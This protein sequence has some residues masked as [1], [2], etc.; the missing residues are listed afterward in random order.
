MMLTTESRVALRELA[1]HLLSNL[2]SS[3]QRIIGTIN[4]FNVW[5]HMI[6]QYHVQKF[7]IKGWIIQFISRFLF[8]A[9]KND[10]LSLIR[11][12][13]HE[14]NLEHVK[15]VCSLFTQLD[16]GYLHPGITRLQ[17]KPSKLRSPAKSY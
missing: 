4:N 17:S 6:E 12:A 5:N 2:Q 3:D 14:E 11:P 16:H 13:R 1:W 8:A 9:E 7:S 15:I 10:V